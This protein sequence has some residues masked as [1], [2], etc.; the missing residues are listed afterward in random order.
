MLNW[1]LRPSQTLGLRLFGFLPD[2]SIHLLSS[3]GINPLSP[4]FVGDICGEKGMLISVDGKHTQVFLEEHCPF[5]LSF[6]AV[7]RLHGW[8]RRRIVSSEAYLPNPW[9]WTAAR[10]HNDIPTLNV[11]AANT[12]HTTTYPGSRTSH[13]AEQP[14]TLQTSPPWPT[15]LPFPGCSVGLASTII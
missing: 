5:A 4:S 11:F 9:D 13:I 14:L 8:L 12:Q 6:P 7:L 2:S 3:L 1:H 15:D 10:E